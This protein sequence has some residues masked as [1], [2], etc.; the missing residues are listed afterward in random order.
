LDKFLNTHRI[1]VVVSF[2][3]IMALAAAAV[4]RQQHA[5]AWYQ[6][7][8]GALKRAWTAVKRLVF[9][10]K[11][12]VIDAV[13]HL[14]RLCISMATLLASHPVAVTVVTVVCM[15]VVA[16]SPPAWLA[17]APAGISVL[18]NIMKHLP[19][20][21]ALVLSFGSTSFE[22]VVGAA[23]ESIALF[24][25][26]GNFGK[27]C[28]HFFRRLAQ[29]GEHNAQREL[30]LL[31]LTVVCF[32]SIFVTACVVDRCWSELI[33]AALVLSIIFFSTNTVWAA[34]IFLFVVRSNTPFLWLRNVSC[35]ATGIHVVGLASSFVGESI[36][37]NQTQGGRGS[38]SSSHMHIPGPG[39]AELGGDHG[40]IKHG[41]FQDVAASIIVLAVATLVTLS[42]RR[43][44]FFGFLLDKLGVDLVLRCAFAN[45][46]RSMVCM[47][48]VL[49]DTVSLATPIRHL[50]LALVLF[51]LH[52]VVHCRGFALAMQKYMLQPSNIDLSQIS[53]TVLGLLMRLMGKLNS[54]VPSQWQIILICI[55][56]CTTVT[57]LAQTI[58]TDCSRPWFVWMCCVALVLVLFDDFHVLFG[59]MLSFVMCNERYSPIA[60]QLQRMR[61]CV[62]RHF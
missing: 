53:G 44:N 28:S 38:F 55:I 3:V 11:E 49:M 36:A 25:A 47:I 17:A 18:F 27:A 51:G 7:W 32:F 54:L 33:L 62:V 2:I 58:A 10:V 35:N 30:K 43:L 22:D 34:L 19:H 61:F 20:I 52:R 46:L 23:G 24:A 37:L 15:L 16:F 39:P 14:H 12:Y 60:S 41:L 31:L 59:A 21:V 4:E 8:W 6:R 26:D 40:F 48:L 57:A 29:S 5:R 50:S 45:A 13:S 9:F 1:V 42:N 56:R